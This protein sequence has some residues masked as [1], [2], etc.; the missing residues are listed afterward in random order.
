MIVGGVNGVW[1][2]TYS[3]SAPS[4][5]TYGP[6]GLYFLD[7]AHTTANGTITS[8]SES[9]FAIDVLYLVNS[10][11]PSWV[12]CPSVSANNAT[13]TYA[14][15]ATEG[16]LTPATSATFDAYTQS[17]GGHKVSSARPVYIY[18][19]GITGIAVL[20]K[21]ND[22]NV[23]KRFSVQ[24]EEVAADGSFGTPNT[25]QSS[26]DKSTHVTVYAAS[27]LDA[28]K[29]YRV[30]LTGS[31]NNHETHQVRF[32]KATYTDTP[33]LT[34][35]LSSAYTG[36][37][38]KMLNL[39][40]NSDCA[41]SYQW[42]SNTTATN[43]GGT[44]ISNATSNTYIYTPAAGDVNTDK[45]FYC[46]ATNSSATGTQSVASTAATVSV[47]AASSFIGLQQP[48]DRI[49]RT[50]STKDYIGTVY[51]PTYTGISH[52][53][54]TSQLGAKCANNTTA[55]TAYGPAG[56]FYTANSFQ[57]QVNSSDYDATQWIGYSV[58]VESG[59]KM[60]L[61]NLS[62]AMWCTD[63]TTFTWKVVVEDSEGTALYTSDETT[64][65]Q[66]A[67]GKISV[68][69]PSGVS[70][71]V[72]GTY[73][74]KLYLYQAGSN[75]YF[76]VPY[77]TFDADISEN[78]TPKHTVTTSVDDEDH[79]TVTETAEY[80][81]GSDVEITAAAKRGFKF[82]DWTIDGTEHKS[83]ANPYTFED[84]AVAH[85]ITANFAALNT[86]TFSIGT[87]P[88]VLGTAPEVDYADTEYTLPAANLMYK[89][90]YTLTAWYDGVSNHAVGSKMSVSGDVSLTP[91]YT[92]NADNV[93]TTATTVDWV[94]A[95]NEGAPSIACENSQL[96]YIQQVTIGG[97]KYDANMLI[98]TRD[99]VKY[100]GASQ[101]G[102]VNNTTQNGVRAQ[103][104][105]ASVFAIPAVHGMTVSY[106]GLQTASPAVNLVGFTDDAS[107]LTG[108]PDAFDDADSG[109][110]NTLTYQYNGYADVLYV[111]D[112]ASYQ[113]PHGLRVTYPRK[114]MP[115]P[116]ISP[117]DDTMFT[118]SSQEVTISSAEGATVYYTLDGSTPTTS[119]SV[120][121]GSSKPTVSS[122][123]TVKAFATMSGYF[124]SDVATVKLTKVIDG[125]SYTYSYTD[126]KSISTLESEGWTFNEATENPTSTGAYVNLVSA[127]NSSTAETITAL[128][129]SGNSTKDFDNNA[130]AFAKNSAV[131]AMYDLGAA[132]KVIRVSG[133]FCVGSSSARTFTIDYI[134]ADGET[135]K[136][137]ITVNHPASNNWGANIV[138]D[139]RVVEDV[140]YIKIK[141][142]ASNQS[143]IVMENFSVVYGTETVAVSTKSGRYYGT[144]VAP[145][146]KKLD[147]SSA[148][149]IT[150]YIAKGFNNAKDAIVLKE[151]GIVPAEEPIIVNTET[152]GATVDVPV[153]TADPSDV[154]ENSLVA[155]DGTTAWNGT[156]G[157]T[158]YYIASDLFHKATSGT[159]QSGKAYL[160]IDS[161]LVPNEARSFGFVVDDEE[162]TGIADVR[163]NVG[164]GRCEYFDLQGRRVDL[165]TKGLYIV[166]GRKVLIP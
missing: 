101:Y 110:S 128:K 82:V 60:S 53:T 70:D 9:T 108:S 67:P 152:Q 103:V 129:K 159:L 141:G 147:F 161:D 164:E 65:A 1:G 125:G 63:N 59:Y 97:V 145:T 163:G 54:V 72:E 121:N 155:G 81:E 104:R 33:T 22:T 23:N 62:A 146:G 24:V 40:V 140:R 68:A 85:T 49:L 17:Y 11:K 153:T 113:Y 142:M 16:F 41:D 123:S 106:Y 46:V 66:L 138:N 28:K 4:V 10:W 31:N 2:A 117:A 6:D 120:Y 100:D 79:G 118:T 52:L 83:T 26:G 86:I 143:W 157:Y 15:A 69:S 90:G 50:V 32:T 34:T 44:P 3:G 166:N 71:L 130:I 87:D 136:S 133:T 144:M 158:Y 127:F 74:V 131:Y 38:G 55:R 119:S 5:V 56:N 51:A 88:L 18:V 42:Y 102:K 36:E 20:H 135:V 37:V 154:S 126:E 116:T 139:S 77:L 111:I 156:D 160:M 89:E 35:D 150:A 124:N 57:K 14:N 45:Y 13:Y 151:I 43:S 134:G 75:K 84:I 137:T 122:T 80:L 149:G 107:K 165:P 61:S 64:S 132:Q 29:F 25:T 19:T 91:V 96:H 48:Y 114:E 47:G 105:L 99:A 58:V 92:K 27:T 109:A 73:Y 78:T 12:S 30:T 7:V 93:W 162:P 8:T 21:D 95:I 115:V 39:Y 94:L 98:D 112:K 76:T 148:D